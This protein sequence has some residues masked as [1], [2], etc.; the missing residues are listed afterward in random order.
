MT[1]VVAEELAEQDLE[2]VSAG[3]ENGQAAG[4]AVANGTVGTARNPYL[5]GQGTRGQGGVQPIKNPPS[6]FSK[7]RGH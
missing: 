3:K 2:R 6:P 4:F 5:K 7:S 1:E